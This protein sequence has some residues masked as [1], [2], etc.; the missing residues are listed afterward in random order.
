MEVNCGSLVA[1][2]HRF[3]NAGCVR[4]FL[5]GEEVLLAAPKI[6]GRIHCNL[7]ICFQ[8]RDQENGVSK[9]G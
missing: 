9:P 1:G 8:N 5:D 2:M 6:N 3:G 7:I 4:V